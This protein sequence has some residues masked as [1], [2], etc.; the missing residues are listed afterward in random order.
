M[1]VAIG[2]AIGLAITLVF[3]KFFGYFGLMKGGDSFGFKVAFR[4]IGEAIL[5]T[6]FI[7]ALVATAVLHS[8]H[9]WHLFF[10]YAGLRA[11]AL[12]LEVLANRR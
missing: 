8:E 6:G 2:C 5:F 4:L 12:T 11:A 9:A 3:A 7:G 10:G 1:Y